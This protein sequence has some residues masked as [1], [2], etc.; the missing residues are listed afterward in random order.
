MEVGGGGAIV[1]EWG[2]G[3]PPEVDGAIKQQQKQHR[4]PN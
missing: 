4:A 3:V 2:K 1:T